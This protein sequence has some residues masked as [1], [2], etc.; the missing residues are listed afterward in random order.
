VS[1]LHLRMRSLDD[2]DRL[3]TNMDVSVQSFALGEVKNERLTAAP[4]SRGIS[5]HHVVEGRLAL[6]LPGREQILCSEGTTILLAPGMEPRIKCEGDLAPK[7]ASA[8]VV[9]QLSD[10]FGL[11]DRAKAPLVEHMGD[12]EIVRQAFAIMLA[13][14]QVSKSRVGKQALVNTLMKICILAVLRR[15]FQRP[16]ID[17]KIIS[18]LADPRLAGPVAAILETPAAPHDV[19][20]LAGRAGMSRSSFARYFTEALGMGPMEFVSRTRLYYAARML[21][22]SETPIKAISASIG[23]SS[24]SHFSKAFRDLYGRDPSA[25]RKEEG[26]AEREIPEPVK[27]F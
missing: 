2:L 27:Y 10:S 26:L 23:F 24:R 8:I 22:S 5:V 19:L 1:L 7:L 4:P 13:E 21:R 16:G 9:A 11:L 12:S 25:Y 15:F 17:Q 3:L 14:N 18:A 6:D 20:A